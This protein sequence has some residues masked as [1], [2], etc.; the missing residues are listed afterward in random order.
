MALNWQN[1]FEAWSLLT[2][3]VP[4]DGNCL[5]HAITMAFFKPYIN[6]SFNGKYVSREQMV[7]N[8]RYELS[9]KLAQPIK[10]GS[11][12]TYYDVMNDGNTAKFAKTVPEFSLRNMMNMLNSNN[13]IGYGFFEFINSQLNKDIFILDGNTQDL[14]YSDE[15]RLS[16][17]GRNSIV[18][19]YQG[20]HYQLVAI[21][22]ND[23]EHTH[24]K[25]DHPFILFLKSKIK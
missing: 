4:M 14:Y 16:I 19:Y 24:F 25:P 23:G 1:G 15:Y 8:L 22:D 20:N 21:V 3:N 12:I 17:K 13:H 7:K 18:L 5:F 11:N 9:K 6:E 2:Y 10:G